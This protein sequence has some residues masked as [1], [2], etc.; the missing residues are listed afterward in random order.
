VDHAAQIRLDLSPLRLL[1]I[2]LSPIA[3]V[4]LI[5]WLWVAHTALFCLD[6]S[7]LRLVGYCGYPQAL[8]H[9]LGWLTLL[10]YNSTPTIAD[11]RQCNSK[12]A[13]TVNC[14]EPA[15]SE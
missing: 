7:P 1:Q 14:T 4:G 3:D 12:P 15:G 6:L 9:G 10:G 13:L 11:T 8:Y 5:S 2:T